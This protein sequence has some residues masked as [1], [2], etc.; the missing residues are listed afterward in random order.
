[1]KFL[2]I[3]SLSIAVMCVMLTACGGGKE[4]KGKYPEN[5][6]KIGDAGR[7]DYVMKNAGPDS[8]ARFIIF[9]SLGKN[10]DVKIDTLALATNYAYEHLQGEALEKFSAEY[11]VVVESLP[12]ADK[13]RAY[14]LGGSEDPQGL[15][16]KL[17]LEY[18]S[19]IR[20]NHKNAA[21]VEKEIAEFKKACGTDTA[22]YRRFLIG[23]RT[24]LEVDRGKDVPEDIYQKFIKLTQNS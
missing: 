5:F 23:F 20:E 3:K 19:S 8:L 7:I 15:G 22:T 11:D 16:Y 21:A 2:D 1:M 24:V 9:S 12:L 13:M 14:M 10:G 6:N 4:G 17:G 18:M